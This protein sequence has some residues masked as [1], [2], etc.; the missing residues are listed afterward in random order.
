MAEQTRNIIEVFY[1]Y[2]NKDKDLQKRLE[3]HLRMP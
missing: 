2:A 3:N 1:A